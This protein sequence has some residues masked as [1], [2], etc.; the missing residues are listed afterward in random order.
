MYTYECR[1]EKQLVY[2]PVARNGTSEDASLNILV[3]DAMSHGTFLFP[4][5]SL[6]IHR[7][8]MTR[9]VEV[10]KNKEEH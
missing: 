3:F 9:T 10:L 1:N 6:L 5:V 8:E 7:N 2:V 4:F